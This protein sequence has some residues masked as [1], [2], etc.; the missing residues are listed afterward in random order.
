MEF[1]YLFDPLC[2]WC[3]GASPA[4]RRLAQRFKLEAFATGLFADTGRTADSGFAEYAWE[5]DMRIQAL[6]GQ[7]FGENYRRNVLQNGGE[8]NSRAL[9]EACYALIGH[10]PEQWTADLALLQKARY[11]DGMDTS[12]RQTVSRILKDNGLGAIADVMATQ[13]NTDRTTAWIRQGQALAQ[14]FG[15]QG[16]PLLIARTEHGFTVIPGQLLYRD[17]DGIEEN[18]RRY[19]NR[20]A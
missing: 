17:I 18:I 8:F 10:R 5:N 15:V 1:I 4:I 16:V 6:T 12:Q 3:Y 20:T 11:E 14:R 7:A 2:G 9:S 13:E 19:L